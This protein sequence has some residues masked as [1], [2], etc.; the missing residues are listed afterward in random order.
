MNYV[1]KHIFSLLHDY[2]NV[3]KQQYE[4]G[5]NLQKTYFTPT[6]LI[7]EWF[8]DTFPKDPMDLISKGEI[9]KAEWSIIKP[10]FY[11]F[12]MFADHYFKNENKIPADMT[13]YEPWKLVIESAEKIKK[14]LEGLGWKLED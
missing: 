1:R 4:W 12:N 7:E 6:E 2:S 11:L 9:T 5:E 3:E 13:E 10:F 14:Q 8:S